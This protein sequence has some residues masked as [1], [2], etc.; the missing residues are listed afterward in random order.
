VGIEPGRLHFSWIASS[1]STKF[2]EVAHTV[3]E[4]VRALGPAKH[5]IKGIPAVKQW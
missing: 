1:E 2:V 4:Q 5:L 3:A